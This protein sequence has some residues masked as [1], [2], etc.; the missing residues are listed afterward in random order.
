M[1]TT[2]ISI[3][4]LPAITEIN[5]NDLIDIKGLLAQLGKTPFFKKIKPTPYD[6]AVSLTWYLENIFY[7]DFSLQVKKF[8]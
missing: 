4:Q 7:N 3:K 8:L 6:E 1:S 5:N 2:E